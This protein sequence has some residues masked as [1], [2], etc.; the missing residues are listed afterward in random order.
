MFSGSY[1][2]MS[3][4]LPNSHSL[5]YICRREVF[6]EIDYELGK[7]F[8]VYHIFRMV[9]ISINNLSAPSNL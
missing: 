5:L 3:R 1:R 9:R 6:V 2:L 8:D 7:L 4:D